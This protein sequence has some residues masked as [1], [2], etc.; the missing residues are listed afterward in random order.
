MNNKQTKYGLEELH[1]NNLADFMETLGKSE[2]WLASRNNRGVNQALGVFNTSNG[3]LHSSDQ[4]INEFLTKHEFVE[5]RDQAN[6]R[7]IGWFDNKERQLWRPAECEFRAKSTQSDAKHIRPS[8]F[9]AGIAAITANIEAERRRFEEPTK[10]NF[11]LDNEIKALG[12]FRLPNKEEL[13][14]FYNHK[15]NFL[16]DKNKNTLKFTDGV[17]YQ[18]W[19]TIIGAVDLT[20]NNVDQLPLAQAVIDKARKHE[21]AF[22]V[23]GGWYSKTAKEINQLLVEQGW[24]LAT[25]SGETTYFSDKW[26]NLAMEQLFAKMVLENIELEAKDDKSIKLIPA[27]AWV[28]TQM[29]E[30][31]YNP[32]RLPK[33]AET[34]LTDPEKGLWELWGQSEEALK[35]F[36]YIARDPLQDIQRRPVAIDFGTSS[37][38]V[39]VTTQNGGQE[40]L[41]VGVRDFYQAVAAQHF[42]NPTVLEFLDFDSFTQEWNKQAYRPELNWNWV[43]ASH[44]AQAS[45]RDNPG[46]T[47]VLASILPRLKQWALRSDADRRIKLTGRKGREMDLQPHLER[48]PVRGQPLSFTGEQPLDPVEL[49]A[50]YLGMAINWRG[51]GLFLKYYLSFPVKYPVEVR[52]RILASFRRGLQRSYPQSL[53]DHHPHILNE[54]EVNDLASEPA[55]YAAAALPHLGIEPTETGVPYAVF[56]FGGGTAD[57]DYGILRW[58][59]NDEEAQGHERV[60]EHVG[61][62]G[63]NFLGAENLLEHL[64]Y[65]TFKLNQDTLRQAHIQFTL[66]MDAIPFSGSELLIATTQAAQTNVVMLSAKLRE[67]MES[68]TADLSSQL[69]MDL[70]DANGKKQPCELQLDAG[71]L[72]SFL[73]KRI[74]SGIYAFFAQLA[75]IIDK[76]PAEPIQILLAGNGSRSRHI[77]QLLENSDSQLN[78]IL[79]EVFG[80]NPPEIKIH[81]PLPMDDKS[82]HTPTSKTGVALGLLKLTPGRG[83]LIKNESMAQQNGQAPFGWFIGRIARNNFKPLITPD[84]DYHEWKEFGVIHGGVF[85]LYATKSPRAYQGL[86]D[87][88][89]ELTFYP[90]SLPDAMPGARLFI[91]AKSPGLVEYA[92]AE[93]ESRLEEAIK[94]ELNLKKLSGSHD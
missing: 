78:D 75:R 35:K 42:E 60:F 11:K 51:R 74:H 59:N 94:L 79:M 39:G 10:N 18:Y 53:I 88:S 15:S 65:E 50:W 90:L 49:Y 34:Q 55:A 12:V 13:L 5:I 43:R 2:H 16:A 25:E 23:S 28:D 36:G 91:R 30:I 20:E 19:P 38:V 92:H 61:S 86:V 72:D 80:Q 14:N 4:N 67:F 52:D 62:G 85:N 76:L 84:D 27:E 56:D 46:D 69:R 48:N 81:A 31:D 41:R 24:I 33:L 6:G 82:P 9:M 77:E 89:P 3:L 45:F 71:L 17:D 70:L 40:L 64:V 58:A 87:G 22:V 26:C 44:E 93:D 57:F 66:P 37:T 54:F 21:K 73:A 29:I 32:C 7:V 47:E 63:D 83:V 68:D 1:A 8:G